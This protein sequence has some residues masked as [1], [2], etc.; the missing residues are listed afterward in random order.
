MVVNNKET[1]LRIHRR[2]EILHAVRSWFRQANFLEVDAPILVPGTGCEPFIDPLETSLFWEVNGPS[3]KRYLHTSPELYLKRLLARAPEPLFYV[4]HVF[5][6]GEWTNRHLPEF[7]MMEW[8]RP[9]GTLEDLVHDCEQWIAYV[10]EICLQKNLKLN[11]D[12]VKTLSSKPYEILPMSYLW[13]KHA[14]ID[15][16]ETLLKVQEKGDEEMVHAVANAGFSLRPN[17]DFDDAFFQV[18][19]S[20]VEPNIGKTCPTVVTQWPRQMAVLS[21]L[22]AADSLFARRFEIYACGLEL[23]NAFDELTDGEEQKRRFR[24]DNQ[25]RA[26]LGKPILSLDEAFL[27]ELDQIPPTVGIAFGLDRLIQLLF[28]LKHLEEAYPL[29]VK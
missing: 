26:A 17:A 20:A 19:L 23:A 9:H 6:N 15:L 16:R 18:M 27:S 14:G 24:A 2:A 3:E 5:R 7:T 25:K 13:K 28:G 11:N 10:I 12:A 22:E 21:K 8:Y 4:G 29:Y 1:I